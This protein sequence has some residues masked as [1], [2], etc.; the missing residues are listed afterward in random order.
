MAG[1]FLITGVAGSGKSTLEKLFKEKGYVTIDID[2]GYAMWRHAGTDEVLAYTPDDESWHDVAEWV[3]DVTKIKR[4]FDEH[5]EEDVL[6]FGSFARMKE[7]VGLFDK[8]FLLEYHDVDIVRDRIAN[9]EDGYGKN[10]HELKRILSYV[11]PYQGK[12]RA[13]GAHPIDCTLPGDRIVETIE[14]EI[15]RD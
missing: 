1:R 10:P 15:H 6:V 8:I 13:Y 14:G 4:F 7:V 2:D 3:V 5:V 11:K 9:R 12:M